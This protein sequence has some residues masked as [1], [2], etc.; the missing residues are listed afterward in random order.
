MLEMAE[1][2]IMSQKDTEIDPLGA[3]DNDRN[4]S[5]YPGSNPDG[6]QTTAVF[7]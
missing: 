7:R 4:Q 2:T 5:A 1:L 3:E 6:N